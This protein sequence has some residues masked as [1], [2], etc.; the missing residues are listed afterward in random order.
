MPK[1]IFI[2]VDDT[3]VRSFGSKRIP[4]S[5]MVA[6]VKELARAGAELYLW[7]SGGA[8]YAAEAA[9]ELAIGDCFKAFLPKPEVL[10]D[11]SPIASWRMTQLHPNECLARNATEMARKD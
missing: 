8:S 5:P 9:R 4:I 7:S 2:D 3:L 6:M 1:A 10:I 11:D